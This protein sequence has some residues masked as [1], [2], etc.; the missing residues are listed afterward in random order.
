MSFISIEFSGMSEV[1]FYVTGLSFAY[2]QAPKSMKSVVQ[3]F[4]L[5][6]VAIGNAVIVIITEMKLFESQA[7]EF[8]LYFCLMIICMIIFIFSACKFRRQKLAQKTVKRDVP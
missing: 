5:L 7:Y 2:E 4:W 6:T 3:S 1:M 8:L